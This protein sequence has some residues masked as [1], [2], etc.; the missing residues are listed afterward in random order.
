MAETN[1]INASLSQQRTS[2][3]EPTQDLDTALDTD[4]DVIEANH[5]NGA[6]FDG[7]GDGTTA[8][9]AGA[10]TA[11]PNLA[12]VALAIDPKITSAKDTTLREFLGKMDEYAPIVSKQPGPFWKE[13]EGRGGEGG[14]RREEE[15]TWELS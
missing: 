13:E 5:A 9:A 1:H 10:E 12:N 3:A 7:A 15:Q 6:N 11:A 8:A 4:M 2:D 14:G